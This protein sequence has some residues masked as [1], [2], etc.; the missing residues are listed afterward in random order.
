[1]IMLSVI[2]ISKLHIMNTD[3]I[4]DVEDGEEGLCISIRGRVIRVYRLQTS[5]ALELKEERPHSRVFP[6]LENN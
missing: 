1:M 2:I 5:T 3:C 4:G 6:S